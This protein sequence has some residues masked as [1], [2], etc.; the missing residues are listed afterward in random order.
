MIKK[1][2]NGFKNYKSNVKG[3]GSFII[4]FYNSGNI[5]TEG[6]YGISHLI[7][8]CMCNQLKDYELDFE[9]YGIGYNASTSL[10]YVNFYITGLDEGIIKFRKLFYDLVVNYEIPKDVF[11]RERNIVIQEFNDALGKPRTVFFENV[12]RKYFNSRTALGEMN[13][14]SNLTYEKFIEYK[15]KY[16]SKPTFI[17][18]T[19]ASKIKRNEFETQKITLNINDLT[20]LE[21]DKSIGIPLHK[22]FTSDT[23]RNICYVTKFT[24]NE[25]TL[26]EY[27]YYSMISKYLCYGL[28][29]PLYKDLR[30]KTG[31]I[32]SVSAY[33]DSLL[34]NGNAYFLI[35][36]TTEPKYEDE[37]K[38]KL[39]ECLNN[40]LNHIDKKIFDNIIIG[41]RNSLKRAD[42]L[43]FSK[44]NTF[45]SKCID[46]CRTFEFDFVKFKKYSKKLL[47]NNYILINDVTY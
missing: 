29:S 45:S 23:S 13:D 5:E 38:E 36:V 31:H 14:L 32:Y 10:T 27:L 1:I 18:N 46:I 2:K 30:E 7:E 39:L 19:S 43:S 25:E 12:F 41:H 47:K 40:H 24:Y 6:Y 8:H 17:C 16:F 42:L 11:E 4:I 9:K 22:P 26:E 3:M 44:A 35:F 34:E 28:S 37:I 15:N 20:G 21:F 33:V